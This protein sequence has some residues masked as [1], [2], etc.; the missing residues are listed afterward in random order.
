MRIHGQKLVLGLAAASALALPIAGAA[1]SHDG[2]ISTVAGTGTPGNSGELGLATLA[3]LQDPRDVAPLPGG[4]F[5]VADTANHVV[6]EVN[7]LGVIT[8]VAGTGADGNTGDGGLATAADMGDISSV[9]PTADGGF[10]I[11]DPDSH[12]VR[13]V[14]ELGVIE[15]VAGTGVGAYGG[16]G[17][18]A[19]AADLNN[20]TDA[21]ELGDGEILI[22]DRGNNRI[23]K[24]SPGGVIETVAGTGLSGFS[25]DGG[26]ATSAEIDD[27]SDISALEDCAFLFVDEANERIRRVDADGTISTV[28]GTG[29]SGPLGDDGPA[30][31]AYL[32]PVGVTA[33]ND[34]GFL[35]A[36]ENDNRV[37]RVDPGGTI[38]TDA[39]NGN[40][41]SGGDGGMPD[42]A[43]LAGPMD[44]TVSPE[45]GYYIAD[46]GN[47]KVRFV[48]SYDLPAGADVTPPDKPEIVRGPG[49][50]GN[51]PT[52]IWHF[53]VPDDADVAEC[54]L[55]RGSEV[56]Y[57]WEHCTSPRKYA[58]GDQPD[59][60]YTFY[61]DAAD[62][63]GNWSEAATDS[64][65]FDQTPPAA[66]VITD[67]PARGDDTTPSFAFK[68]E[69]GAKF[70]CELARDGVTFREEQCA[71]PMTYDLAGHG[72]GTYGFSVKAGDAAGNK[73]GPAKAE[74]VLEFRSL[75]VP[76]EPAPKLGETV[77]A[78]TAK[79]T[80]LVKVPG[81]DRWVELGEATGLPVGSRIDARRG[82]AVLSSALN[83]DGRTQRA[84]FRG[85]VFEVRQG[86]R[87]RGVTDILL[88]GRLACHG[89]A[90]RGA[91]V[92]SPSRAS[93][94]R[95][96]LWG[97]DN[98][99][100]WRTH[101]QNS[102]ATVRGTTW[103]TQDRCG[104]TLTRV[105][106]GAVLVRNRHGGRRVLV[107]AGGSYLARK[108][109]R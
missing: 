11:A 15:T 21:V 77:V 98:G 17:G 82:V 68:G 44:V 35:I 37:R 57:G 53:E 65:K 62:T 2:N 24:V 26:P 76:D 19:T 40:T 55:K 79:G 9:S 4:G 102:V 28:A 54:K 25:G 101:G 71:S 92:A 63:A 59:G 50:L 46:A 1:L 69:E 51:N 83:R 66:P 27:P 80:A 78:G 108:S 107:K 91:A 23:R 20:P 84:R 47:H 64:Y 73:S 39:G 33:L 5:L 41:G 99:G 6:R 38:T 93:R 56:V 29:S 72:A 94:R 12:V 3:E 48:W 13:K 104:G 60:L 88:R 106:E 89:T 58:L 14:S 32:R 8:R 30:T 18:Q 90:G 96:S 10:L 52:P 109:R 67:A 70:T 34:G 43:E 87:S 105:T 81:S 45:G 75:V 103:L 95:R 86:R 36:D 49:K 97:R 100:R 42:V 85:G 16:D 22:A 61:V 31:D 74:Y 7:A